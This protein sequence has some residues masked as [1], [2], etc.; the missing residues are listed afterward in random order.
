MRQIGLPIMIT[1]PFPYNHP[2]KNGNI[3]TKEAVQN[4]IESL[5]KGMPIIF[6]GNDTV[7]TE[8]VIGHTTDKQYVVDD[9]LN[10]TYRLTVE[11]VI[12]AG[13]T[14]CIVDEIKD[15]TINKFEIVSLGLS[16]PEPEE[17]EVL[18]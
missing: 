18:K 9:Y 14:E 15:R 5:Q 1:I 13:G 12:A 10:Q 6:R 4:A 16:L 7:G 11:G 17:K 2:D 8:F 3:Y